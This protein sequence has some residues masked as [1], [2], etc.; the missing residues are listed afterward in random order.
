MSNFNVRNANPQ[1]VGK[2]AELRE[3]ERPGEDRRILNG[4]IHH[5]DEYLRD[6]SK[7]PF[8][9]PN[10]KFDPRAADELN[11]IEK[12]QHEKEK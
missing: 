10:G 11:R 7:N 3:S 9:D 4:I 8:H 6:G 12:K 1:Q 2:A 5:K